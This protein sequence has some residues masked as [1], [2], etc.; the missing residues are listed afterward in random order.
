M[1][2]VEASP[3]LLRVADLANRRVAI[4]GYGRE[5]R[6]TLAALRRRFPA[7]PLTLFCSLAEASTVPAGE[8][9]NPA[10]DGIYRRRIVITVAADETTAAH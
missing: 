2:P 4:W 3:A 10:V 7:K 8:K 6:A 1:P 9:D 5:G